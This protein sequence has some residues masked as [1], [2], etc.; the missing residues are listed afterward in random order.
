[1]VADCRPERI[2]N[3]K[4][5]PLFRT[6]F[7][8]GLLLSVL[9]ITACAPPQPP[10]TKTI[11]GI[12]YVSLE[13]VKVMLSKELLREEVLRKLGK[14]K[15]PPDANSS[16]YFYYE[17]PNNKELSFHCLGPF[18]KVASYDR[19][20]IRNGYPKGYTFWFAEDLKKR[21]YYPIFDKESFKDMD[22]CLR[23][24]R[25]LPKK[26]IV[27]WQHDD[28]TFFDANERKALEPLMVLFRDFCK[29]RGFVLVEFMGG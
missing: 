4:S 14:P 1:M 18:I 28:C 23:R 27:E 29:E 21:T 19:E 9:V 5:F 13:D 10:P 3:M 22:S 16:H 24:M 17:L 7:S 15:S 12:T 11:D 6:V 26:T 20:L 8:L 2:S 25:K